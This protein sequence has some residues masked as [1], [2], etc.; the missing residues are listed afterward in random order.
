MRPPR[1]KCVVE[2]GS[3]S[4]GQVGRRPVVVIR[5]FEIAVLQPENGVVGLHPVG[6]RTNFYS[7]TLVDTKQIQ[8]RALQ[9]TS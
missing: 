7:C 4:A 9:L 3:A 6:T 1:P 2:Y 5:V 8:P